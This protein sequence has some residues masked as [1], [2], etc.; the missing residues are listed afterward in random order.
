MIILRTCLESIKNQKNFKEFLSDVVKN[1][2]KEA[3]LKNSKDNISCIFMAF[4]NM[5][6]IFNNKNENGIKLAIKKVELSE[7]YK[8]LYKE[9]INKK[10]YKHINYSQ[11][12][13]KTNEKKEQKNILYRCCGLFK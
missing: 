13:N 1:V 4:E 7:D 10:F 5:L 3:I 2:I 12:H 8:T 6:N 11:I 9:T